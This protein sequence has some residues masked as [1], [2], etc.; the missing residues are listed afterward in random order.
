MRPV[1][2]ADFEALAGQRLDAA[3]WAHFNGGAGDE[4]TQRQNARAWADLALWPRVL[5]PLAHGSAAT[6]LL[7]RRMALP[8]LLAPVAH[9]GLAHPDA[10]LASALGAASQGAGFVLSMLSSRKLEAV[11]AP[12]R[13]DP[14]RGPL[15]FQLYWLHD[16]GFF[17][18]SPSRTYCGMT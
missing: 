15:W 16:R 3:S 14:D 9:Q 2:L 7:E 12:V 10:E 4:H 18:E 11:A 17:R 1:N 6:R 8:L 5:R 13:D